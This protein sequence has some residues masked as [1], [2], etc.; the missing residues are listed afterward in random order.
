MSKPSTVGLFYPVRSLSGA[1][2][3]KGV[4][5]KNCVLNGAHLRLPGYGDGGPTLEIFQYLENEDQPAVLPNRRGFGHIVF[6]VDD[7]ERVMKLVLENGGSMFGTITKNEVVG[8]DLLTF[9]YTRD[10]EGN[11]IELQHWEK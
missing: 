9:V 3:D 4:G 6:E 5:L 7:V 8:A 2:R 11:L 1:W 10:P